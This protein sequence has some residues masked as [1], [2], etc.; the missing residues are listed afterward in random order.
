MPSGPGAEQL[1]SFTAFLISLMPMRHEDS[2]VKS[3]G[4]ELRVLGASSSSS[5]SELLAS[6]SFAGGSDELGGACWVPLRV[7]RW[8]MLLEEDAGAPVEE[9]LACG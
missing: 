6:H 8:L 5:W 7:V 2:S 9:F 3:G 4:V 1:D